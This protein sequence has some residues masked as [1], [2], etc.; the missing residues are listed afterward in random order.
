M[1]KIN[2]GDPFDAQAPF[3]AQDREVLAARGIA[4]TEAERQLRL[5]RDPPTAIH[6][7]RPC[8]IGDGIVQLASEDHPELLQRFDEAA[9]N[10]RFSR[11]VPASGA[12]SR[13]FHQLSRCLAGEVESEDRQALERFFEE[14]HRFAFFGDLEQATVDAGHDLSNHRQAGDLAVLRRLLEADG[15]GYR[16]LPKGLIPF[17]RDPSSP[18]SPGRTA[19]EEHLREATETLAA[20]VSVGHQGTDSPEG[21]PCRIHFTVPGDQQDLCRQ[22]FADLAER[23]AAETGATFDISFSVQSPDTDTLALDAE[24]CPL[25]DPLGKLQFRP[26]GHGALIT[27]L[28][29]WATAP[30]IDLVFIKNIDNIQPSSRRPLPVLW[31]RLLGGY[32]LKLEAAILP[33]LVGCRT[34][35]LSGPQLDAGLDFAVDRLA[36]PRP[37]SWSQWTEGTRRQH[38]LEQ[39]ERPLRVCGVVA[40]SGEPGGGPFW[41]RQTTKDERHCSPQIVETSQIDRNIPR[42]AEILAEASHFNPVDVVCRLRSDLGEVYDLPAFVD[43][44]TVFISHKSHA[45]RP[46]LALERPGLWNGAMARWNTVFVEVPADTFAPV[47]TIFDLLRPEHQA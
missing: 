28:R 12:A 27:N 20:E 42:Q 34:S 22:V 26:G 13:M 11:F 45:G 14:L 30:G 16:H 41:V 39:L 46:L 21:R 29:R 33:L 40:N 10:G 9:Q 32:L 15:L 2:P 4:V 44:A 7:D 5:L 37:A 31:K 19:V 3:S 1:A 18:S 38:L 24:G 43:P 8:T 47:K 25:R 23:L 35:T 36:A 6:L 17:H